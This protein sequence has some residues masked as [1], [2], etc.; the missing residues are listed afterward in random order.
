MVPAFR[1]DAG[2]WE[3]GGVVKAAWRKERNFHKGKVLT[4]ACQVTL[5]PS[6]SPAGDP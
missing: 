1:A 6:E 4:I 2:V 5:N 3:G